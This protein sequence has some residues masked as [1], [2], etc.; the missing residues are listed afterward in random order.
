MSYKDKGKKLISWE[1]PEFQKQNRGLF[2]YVVSI[3]LSILLLYYSF[4]TGNFMF[5]FIIIMV[6]I[7]TLMQTVKEPMQVEFSITDTGLSIGEKFFPY[8]EIKDFWIV[9]EPPEVKKLFIN[10][11]SGFRPHLTIELKEQNPNKIRDILSDY[12]EE[13]LERENEP[14]SEELGRWLKL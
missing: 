14:F 6:I 9:Y 11:K 7:I 10:F 5:I 2:W 12:I 4:V 8:D 3:I 13:D 1:F